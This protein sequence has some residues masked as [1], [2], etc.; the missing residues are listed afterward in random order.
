MKGKEQEGGGMTLSLK[1]GG[2]GGSTPNLVR[3][4]EGRGVYAGL[5]NCT[6]SPADG[7]GICNQSKYL[8]HY[9]GITVYEGSAGY[10]YARSVGCRYTI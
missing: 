10:I 4:G 2:V 5:I 8:I 6:F 9:F 1:S 7:V 3:V